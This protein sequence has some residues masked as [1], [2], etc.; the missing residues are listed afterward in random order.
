MFLATNSIFPYARR[1]AAGFPLPVSGGLSRV[2][3]VGFVVDKVVL[4]PVFLWVI[5]L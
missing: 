4:G 2:V 5:L 1:L 3:R